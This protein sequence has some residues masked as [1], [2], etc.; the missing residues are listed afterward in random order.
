MAI[1]DDINT[2]V[3]VM[4]E[5]RSFDK[6]LGH[7]LSGEHDGRRGIHGP[8]EAEHVPPHGSVQ[9]YLNHTGGG[10][11]PPARM[12]FLTP[13]DVPV[14]NFFAR[15]F[16]VC[17]HWF[18]H[19]PP[20][21]TPN[22]SP[23]SSGRAISG[24]TAAHTSPVC[25]GSFIF[26]WLNARKVDWRVYHSGLSFFMLFNRFQAGDGP[27]FRHVRDFAADYLS[28]P[29]HAQPSV[30]FIEPE[31]T[32]S[33]VDS[34][35]AASHGDDFLREIYTTLSSDPKK[36][37][38]TLLIAT[39]DEH[40]GFFDHVPPPVETRAR[41]GASFTAP[42]AGP[43]PRVP[44]MIVS[45][46]IGAAMVFKGRMDHT[47]I[48][49][50][51]AEKFDPGTD[52]NDEVRRRRLAGV[53]SVGVALAQA[54]GPLRDNIPPVPDTA[55]AGGEHP[56]RASPAANQPSFACE[57]DDQCARAAPARTVVGMTGNSDAATT[58]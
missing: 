20:A 28:G 9:S 43:G 30:I 21:P 19:V 42:F 41:A 52:Y 32:D 58:S 3:V 10:V 12:A 31:Y 23:G 11:N 56:L 57:C 34:T 55:G 26:D 1:L 2:I 44:A 14:S 35:N 36:F 16:L 48:L 27:R 49:Q 22:R 38:Q 40:G 6:V 47:S 7:M 15:Q 37:A 54:A 24:N 17:D 18:S 33:Q 39:C 13:K 46:R 51:L 29:A 45:P 53:Q 50:L 8:S 25:D 4:L 5:S